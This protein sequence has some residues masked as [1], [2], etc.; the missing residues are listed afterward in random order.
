MSVTSIFHFEDYKAWV[1]TWVE[2]QPRNGF[3]EYR[4]MSQALNVSTTMVSQVF[5]G[6]KHLSLEL[7]SDLCDYLRLDE[8]ETDFFLLL[9]DYSRAGS[10]KL[11]QRLLRQIKQRQ[12]KAK[13]LENR[14]KATEL[15]DHDKAVYYSSWIYSGIR[16]LT[17]IE[18]FQDVESIANHLKMEKNQIQ[19]VIDFMLQRQLIVE[20]KGKLKMG[21][22]VTYIGSSSPL[23]SRFHQNWRLLAFDKM[24]Q[25]DDDNF[26]FTTTFAMSDEV[27]NWVRL[28]LPSFIENIKARVMPSK[29]ETVRC[30]NI[31]YYRY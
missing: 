2:N 27:A 6:D 19:R 11:Q 30:L 25:P 13:K 16:M 18:G 23:V 22:A 29:S 17:D 9:V 24:V 14:V 15:N 3:G 5:K 1:N 26:F 12:A 4:R 28:E 21:P 31:D 10:H 8:D 7:A 20:N